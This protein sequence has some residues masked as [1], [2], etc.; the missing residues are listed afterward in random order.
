[1]QQSKHEAP[2][3]NQPGHPGHAM[4]GQAIDAVTALDK[5]YQRAPDER[6]ANLA[7]ALTTA[8]RQQG[9]SRIDHVVLSEDGQR[10]YAVQGDLN[11]PFKRMAEVSTQEATATPIAR[12]SDAWNLAAPPSVA[13][14][15]EPSRDQ[16]TRQAL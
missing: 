15:A 11:S 7:A 2:Q 9:L 1:M 12:S 6:S 10:A 13:V 16:A 14:P 8:A 5:Q 3:L 4:Y